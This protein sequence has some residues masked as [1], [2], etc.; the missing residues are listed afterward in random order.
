MTNAKTLARLLAPGTVLALCGLLFW[1]VAGCIRQPGQND[2][3]YVPVL[4]PQT[5]TI[6]NLACSA[7]HAG[8]GQDAINPLIAG[9]TN[10]KGKHKLHAGEYAIACVRCHYGYATNGAHMNGAMDAPDRNV[11][12]VYFEPALTNIHWGGDA[13]VQSG[14]CS[15][16]SNAGCHTMTPVNRPWYSNQ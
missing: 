12:I 4:N 14:T 5:N 13:G 15:G 9:G 1:L 3:V 16:A 8:A 6:T 10:V 11:T 7:C 2:L